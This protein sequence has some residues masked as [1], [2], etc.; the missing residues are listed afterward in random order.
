MPEIASVVVRGGILPVLTVTFLVFQSASAQQADAGKKPV[1][2]Q[3]GAPGQPSR[4]LS[5]D[6]VGKLPPGSPKNVEFMQ[7]MIV[8]HQQAVDMV[9]LMK[10]RTDNEDLLLLGARISQSQA[11]EIAFMKRW[12]V[13]RGENVSE[14]MP[15][16]DMPGHDMSSHH[17]MPGML[18]PAQMKELGKAEGKKFDELF[19]T[20]MIQHHI[21]ALVMVKDLFNSP[22][23]GQDP[24]LFN[25]A[26]DIDSGQ[27]AEIRIMESMLGNAPTENQ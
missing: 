2:V 24:E 23:A 25:F 4:K 9:A 27:R 26:T 19:L 14:M 18:T 10:E 21:G 16:M 8:H 17:M 13:T 12:L 22:G 6:T 3:P 7:G 5:P 1:I 20:G 15:G 11:A